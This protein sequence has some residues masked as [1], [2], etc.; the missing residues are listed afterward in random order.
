VISTLFKITTSCKLGE[1]LK[2]EGSEGP[3]PRN[4][5]VCLSAESVDR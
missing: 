5:D 4:E 3:G 1:M 2:G